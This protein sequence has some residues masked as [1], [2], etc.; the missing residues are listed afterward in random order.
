MAKKKRFR[1]L[2]S[3]LIVLGFLI[4]ALMGV[5]FALS[6]KL[7]KGV[8]GADADALAHKMATAINKPAWDTTEVVQWTFKG[9]HTFVWDKKRH[10]TQ[11]EWGAYRV[12]L[13]I[14]NKTGL[15]WKNGEL[16]ADNSKT[17]KLVEQA[18]KYWVNDSFWLNAPA[19]AFD[20]GTTRK[21]VDYEGNKALLVMYGS[22]G[23]TP[24]DAYLWILDDNGLPKAWKLWV[25][26]IPIGGM[27]FSW[28]GWQDLETGAKIATFHKGIIDIDISN[29]K[30]GS[31]AE[32]FGE[33]I[34]IQLEK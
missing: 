18:W 22:G 25:K 20:N 10:L 24:G 5:K 32:L 12:I 30:A 2:K 29:L 23:V 28:Q 27:E 4:L 19:K 9:L 34:F 13:D 7:P 8:A 15:A 11:V 26:I 1:I 6:E 21:I 17:L 3:I 33:D 14:N 16:I 31:M